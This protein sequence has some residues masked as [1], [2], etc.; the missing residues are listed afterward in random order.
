M[1]NYGLSNKEFSI[2]CFKK[3]SKLKEHTNR[4]VIEV[5]KP[6]Q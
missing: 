5:R 2:I 6:M 4:K 3:L 1:E